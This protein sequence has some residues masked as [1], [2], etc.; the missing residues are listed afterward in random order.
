MDI[1]SAK[2]VPLPVT[3]GEHLAHRKLKAKRTINDQIEEVHLVLIENEQYREFLEAVWDEQ[4]VEGSLVDDAHCAAKMIRDKA[5]KM[6][7][8]FIAKQKLATIRHSLNVVLAR[9][10]FGRIQR[11]DAATVGD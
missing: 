5:Q 4:A 3:T 10:G 11:R 2:V 6:G 9:Y 1:S 8:D 7:N